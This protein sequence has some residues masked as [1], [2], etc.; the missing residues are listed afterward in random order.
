MQTM[1]RSIIKRTINVRFSNEHRPG[2]VHAYEH[3]VRLPIFLSFSFLPSLSLLLVLLLV[4]VIIP[5]QPAIHHIVGQKLAGRLQRPPAP[6]WPPLV[7]LR[8]RVRSVVYGNNRLPRI[9]SVFLENRFFSKNLFFFE[10]RFERRGWL[11]GPVGQ[12]GRGWGDVGRPWVALEELLGPLRVRV[13]AHGPEQTPEA[14][15]LV[16]AGAPLGSVAVRARA[17]PRR[18]APLIRAVAPVAAALPCCRFAGA[19]TEQCRQAGLRGG[20]KG[21]GARCR[22]GRRRRRRPARQREVRGVVCE[23]ADI[24]SCVS[25]P[26]FLFSSRF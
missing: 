7:V 18:C 9:E 3:L 16:C 17:A 21:D 25:I 19:S 5:R 22:R 6:P 11:Y 26:L 1:R 24:L 4:S 15:S 23:H 10:N 12:V 20:R 8:V 13:G 2:I 14:P